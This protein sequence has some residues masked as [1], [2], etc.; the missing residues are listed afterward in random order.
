MIDQFV[1]THQHLL[2]EQIRLGLREEKAE[3]ISYSSWK[4]KKSNTS[5]GDDKNTK[6]VNKRK[7]VERQTECLSF[8]F[9]NNRPNRRCHHH[10][11]RRCAPPQLQV[12]CAEKFR[13]KLLAAQIWREDRFLAFFIIGQGVRHALP[14]P[15]LYQIFVRVPFAMKTTIL[16][17]NAFM[18]IDDVKD[19]IFDQHP[20][21]LPQSQHFFLTFCSK[22][23][24]G[25]RALSFYGIQYEDTLILHF[26][27]RGGSDVYDEFG[28]PIET[29]GATDEGPSSLS[30]RASTTA[31]RRRGG[32]T[33]A[34]SETDHEVS[35]SSWR[36]RPVRAGE[37]V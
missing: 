28:C 7:Q 3:L 21:C 34:R 12:H 6:A 9:D 23:L 2:N 31:R 35:P 18:T 37:C 24:E 16:E 8:R 22:Q 19:L 17:V 29:G 33:R 30:S 32:S 27:L 11:C 4:S 1:S 14:P 26:R 13:I 36:W 20:Q 5:P 10:R 15:P 25:C